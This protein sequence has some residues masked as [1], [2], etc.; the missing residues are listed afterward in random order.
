MKCLVL[1]G[2]GYIGSHTVKELVDRG[3]DPIVVDN[4][5]T[6]HRAAVDE[7]VPFHLGDIGDRA[8]ID[9]VFVLEKPDAV[10]HFAS[11]SQVGES[12]KDPM[13]YYRNNLCGTEVL[14]ESM[15]KHG[16]KNI[17]FSSTAATYGEPEKIPIEEAD[18]TH[19]TNPYGE[20]KLAMEKMI[21]WCAKAH[22]IRYV[23]LRYF[24]ACGADKDGKI[25]EAHSP[26]SHLI[27][28]VLQAAR[29][30][31]E[32]ISVFGSDYDTHDGTCIRDYV[33]VSDLAT[34]HI[35]ALEYLQNG[36]HSNVFN[37]GSECGFS[38]LEIIEAARRITR[39]EIKVDFAPRR[40]GDP[41]RLLA[42]CEKAKK[43]L[44][45]SPSH[46]SL[47]EIISSAW[48]FLQTHPNGYEE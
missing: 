19:P 42:S 16:V 40:D 1:G 13:K 23:A 44:N 41:A 11:F 27:P 14:L 34:A 2:A 45:F 33:H 43:V 29:G 20:T 8:F 47:D 15:V 32:S 21:D 46:S 38:V 37:L 10:V 6:G 22:G 48:H 24:N 3:H 7:T 25:G 26:E 12:T 18:K 9:R 17:V 4:L 39:R 36:G 28:L 30:T 5:V 35:L 31:R